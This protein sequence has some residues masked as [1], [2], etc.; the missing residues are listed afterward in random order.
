MRKR[1]YTSVFIYLTKRLRLLR[2]IRIYNGTTY[3][4]FFRKSNVILDTKHRCVLARYPRTKI[5]YSGSFCRLSKCALKIGTC[6][7]CYFN[8]EL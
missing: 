5:T 3:I 4:D 2:Y 1:P 7:E 8:H 6:K